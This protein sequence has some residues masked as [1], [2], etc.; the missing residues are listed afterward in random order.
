M[1]INLGTPKKMKS[2]TDAKN[3]GEFKDSFHTFYCSKEQLTIITIYFVII[4]YL[5]VKYMTTTGHKMEMRKRTYT[6]VQALH[7]V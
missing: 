4:I 6:I 2:A 3:E 5:K 1:K 7:Y